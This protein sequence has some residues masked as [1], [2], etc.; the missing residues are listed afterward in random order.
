MVKSKEK[1]YTYEA[2]AVVLGISRSTIYN[3]QRLGYIPKG[4]YTAAKLEEAVTLVI[5][6][7]RKELQ[8]ELDEMTGRLKHSIQGQ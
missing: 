4:D 8:V 3:W 6:R 7:K 2:V 5:E 1:N